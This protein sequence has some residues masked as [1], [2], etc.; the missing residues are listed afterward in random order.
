[1]NLTGRQMEFRSTRGKDDPYRILILIIL[2]MVGL[3]VIKSFQRGNL[4]SP[5]L[6]TAVPTRTVNSFQLE[7]ETHFAAG[8]LNGAIEAY[9]KAIEL[10]PG[11]IALYSEIS[12]IE[13]Y[14]TT[15]LT[16]DI[17]KQQRLLEALE[18]VNK[19]V[20]VAP[21]DANIWAIKSFVENWI[22]SPSLVG[23]D[24]TRY[25]TDAEQSAVR[26]LQL[27]SKN[28]LALV[29]YAEILID[30][31]KWAQAKQYIEQALAQDSNSM[32]AHRVYGYLMETYGNYGEAIN[33]YKR[34]L[35]INP[36][37]TYLYMAIGLNYRVLERWDEAL[38]Y[39]D[40][41]ARINEQQGIKNPLPYLAIGKTYI[42]QGFPLVAAVNMKKALSY[43]PY[44]PEVYGQLGIVYYTGRNY[45]G[46]LEALKCATLG[47]TAEETCNVRGL[48]VDGVCTGETITLGKTPIT[49]STVSY[50]YTYGS[51]LAGLHRPSNNY[52][53]QAKE[54]FNMIKTEY[55][56]DEDVMAIIRPSENICANAS[57]R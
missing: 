32:D 45:E 22:A 34:G 49:S 33:A 14:S 9:K 44:S 8:N 15:L 31:Q 39:F 27:D 43:N 53:V 2:I 19:G 7:G 54:I 18:T 28:T 13:A 10:D 3:V 47:C 51:A 42:R 48:L 5:F 55:G 6:P 21:E 46:A 29:Y 50:Y 37:F 38:V 4:Q 40:K 1:M 56:E 17:E 25:A 26:A 36:N 12:R 20:E 52:C 57:Y 41:A 35:E 16:T 30:Q 24:A 11:N 23:A